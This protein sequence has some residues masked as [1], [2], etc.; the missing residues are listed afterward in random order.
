MN[1]K[2]LSTSGSLENPLCSREAARFTEWLRKTTRFLIAAYGAAFRPVVEWVE[3]QDHVIT[4]DELEQQL[5]PLSE[6]P[7]DEI[8]E[9]IDQVHVAV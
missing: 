6:V 7:V 9:R 3:D 5:G 1:A 8:L 2:V 4:N